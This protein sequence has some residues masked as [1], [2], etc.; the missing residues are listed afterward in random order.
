MIN[1]YKMQECL[2]PWDEESIFV[3]KGFEH[4]LGRIQSLEGRIQPSAFAEKVKILE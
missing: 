1:D 2:N 3:R 4:L